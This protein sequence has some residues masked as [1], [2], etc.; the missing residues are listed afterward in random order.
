LAKI[1]RGTNVC[2]I[3]NNAYIPVNITD[4]EKEPNRYF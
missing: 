3:V 2:G 1:R 4:P